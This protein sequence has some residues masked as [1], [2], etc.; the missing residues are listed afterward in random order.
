M[1]VTKR[2]AFRWPLLHPGQTVE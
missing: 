2:C 1:M